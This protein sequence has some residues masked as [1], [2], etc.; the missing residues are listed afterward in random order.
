MTALATGQ[1]IAQRSMMVDFR[2][3]PW[4]WRATGLP[5][6]FLLLPWALRRPTTPHIWVIKAMAYEG[7]S[8]YIFLVIWRVMLLSAW[9]L[10]RSGRWG[11][12]WWLYLFFQCHLSQSFSIS[13]YL[14]LNHIKGETKRT[15]FRSTKNSE[16]GL[17]NSSQ[18]EPEFKCE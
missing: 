3:S 10:A 15:G 13:S 11:Q 14:S 7:F 12:F 16:A 4:A 1:S 5:Q 9:E 2:P 6:F 17:K 8:V 18:R